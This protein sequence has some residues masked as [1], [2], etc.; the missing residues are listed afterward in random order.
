[1]GRGDFKLIA[2]LM[3]WIGLGE[4]MNFLLISTLSFLTFNV[5]IRV[6]Q[7]NKEPHQPFGPFLCLSCFVIVFTDLDMTRLLP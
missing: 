3:T 2:A 4:T 1:M 5:V 7:S 6:A